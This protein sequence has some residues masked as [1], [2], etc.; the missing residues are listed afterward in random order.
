MSLSK[1]GD[2]H[3]EAG[4]HASLCIG[5]AQRVL[6]NHFT[7]E[8]AEN[9]EFVVPLAVAMMNYGFNNVASSNLGTIRIA[10]ALDDVAKALRED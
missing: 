10:D 9:P 6:S 3:K 5:E 1:F 2:D 7:E 4:H 8:Q